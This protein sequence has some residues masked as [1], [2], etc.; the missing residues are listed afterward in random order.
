MALYQDRGAAIG[1][2]TPAPGMIAERYEVRDRI[3]RGAFGEVFEVY[4][5]R[6]GR[7]VALKALTIGAAAGA[8]ADEDMRRFQMEARAV[9]RLSHPG[10]VT[11]H[12]FGQTPDFAWIAMELVIG[13]T[14]K[15]VLDRGERPGLTE[16][17]RVTCALLDALHYAHGRGIVHRDVKPANILLSMTAEDGLGEVRLTDFG[18]A[19]IG[20]AHQT[21][22]GQIIGTPMAMSP[23]QVRGQEVD[24]RSDLWS[25]GVIL[26]QLLTGRHPFPGDMAVVFNG[27]L[28]QTPAPPSQLAAGL[29]PAL[30]AVVATALAKQPKDRYADA[31]AMA[32]ALRAATAPGSAGA[33]AGDQGATVRLP[34]PV[35]AVAAP[36]RRKPAGRWGLPLALGFLVG[37]GC[38]AFA[39]HQLST[40]DGLATAAG[41]YRQVAGTKPAAAPPVLPPTAL[42]V[43]PDIPVAAAP[44]V[45]NA[46]A[47]EPAPQP[48]VA[49]SEAKPPAIVSDIEPDPAP[50]EPAPLAL[51]PPLHRPSGS[52]DETA[53]VR[54]CDPHRVATRTGNHPGFGRVVFDWAAPMRFDLQQ[55]EAGGLLRFPEAGCLPSVHGLVL[56]R[57]IR[58]LRP[59]EEESGLLVGI[60]PGARLR[61]YRMDGNRVVIDVLDENE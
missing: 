1:G 26:Y 19:R 47:V 22:T 29:P 49:R 21:M 24:Q 46:P 17:I 2:R 32:S 42:P 43:T 12:D 38:G 36:A 3:G 33:A 54:I 7:L 4:D 55:T 61:V 37:A 14:L 11:V 51:T 5:H 59:D 44:A 23:E 9:A 10:I 35:M 8:D 31:A 25:V 60:T 20:E 15:A 27:I 40:R 16:T 41:W 34:A 30:D 48:Q 53:D 28:T 52:T 18:I 39:M 6:L 57:N 45:V 50:A 13:E 56:P 58:S